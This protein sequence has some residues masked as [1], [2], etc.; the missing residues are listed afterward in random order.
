MRTRDLYNFPRRTYWLRRL[1]NYNRKERVPVDEYTIEH[2]MP[3][4]ENVSLAW[5]T[6][7]GPEWKRVQQTW[8]HSLGNL[9]LTGY[10]SEYSD[11]PFAE[12]RDMAG[13]F[14]ESPLRLNS[15]LGKLDKWDE[16]EIKARAATL[17]AT[18]V[19]VWAGPHLSKEVL[20]GYTAKS[21][22]ETSYSID[23]HPYLAGGANRNLFDELRKAVLALDPCVTEEFLK[24]YIAYKAETNF[25]DVVPQA[26]RLRLSLKCHLAT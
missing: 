21:V 9:T 4:N 11:R 2:I 5:R 23:D 3:Q 10:N 22:S 6:A 1:E 17:S 15:G 13:G 25:I 20:A 16:D 7:L 18:A 26:K 24:R 19:N 12:K 8:L 14:K